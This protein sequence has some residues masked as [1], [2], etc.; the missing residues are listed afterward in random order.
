M[1]DLDL[2]TVVVDSSKLF[3]LIRKRKI[4]MYIYG[5][6]NRIQDPSYFLNTF[7]SPKNIANYPNWNNKQIN[8]LNNLIQKSADLNVRKKLHC[9][10]EKI[11]HQEVPSIPL[12]SNSIYSLI[13]PN[14]YDIYV[15]GAKE[16][17]LRYCY[18]K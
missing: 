1:F 8:S 4:N 7:S 5:W 12:I 10:A 13:Q 14:I 17:D 11:L 15:G 6:I 18:K 2:E 3:L 16:F 9:Q